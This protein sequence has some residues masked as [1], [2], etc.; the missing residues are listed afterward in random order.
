M[1]LFIPNKDALLELAN[2]IGEPSRFFKYIESTYISDRIDEVRIN[3]E[4]QDVDDNINFSQ[5]SE[6]E[7]Q[8]HTVLG[9]MRFTKEDQALFLIDEPDTHLNPIWKLRYFD[10]IEKL[11]NLQDQTVMGDSQLII[12]THDPMMIGGLRKE[13]V[14][15]LR[16]LGGI[17]IVEEAD[18]HPKGMGVAGL[19]KSSL[20]GLT[21]TLDRYTLSKLHKRNELLAKSKKTKLSDDD[22]MEIKKLRDYLDNLGF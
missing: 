2:K 14:R 5:L 4:Q 3:V 6:G 15:V 7:Q 11:V 13:Q 16:N 21:S 19:L 10:E 22:E 17:A 9:L 18:E 8:L 12:A 20:F 1:Y